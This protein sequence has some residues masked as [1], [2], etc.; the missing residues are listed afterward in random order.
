PDGI[1]RP[2]D[3]LKHQARHLCAFLH[4]SSSFPRRPTARG[5]GCNKTQKD[6]ARPAA[7]TTGKRGAFSRAQPSRHHYP[8]QLLS[9]RRRFAARLSILAGDRAPRLRG[10]RAV[11]TE[12]ADAARRAR[13][14]LG[15]PGATKRVTSA[16]AWSQVPPCPNSKIPANSRTA[17]S[18]S[19]LPGWSPL[20]QPSPSSTFRGCS[21]K[22]PFGLRAPALP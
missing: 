11:S 14:Y 3:V 22:V 9:R 12:G 13:L 6:K 5:A 7:A 8:R 16:V 20:L 18:P 1:V 19:L 2:R 21:T 10:R 17:T 15:E 4:A